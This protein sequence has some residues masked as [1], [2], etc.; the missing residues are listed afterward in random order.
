MAGSKSRVSPAAEEMTVNKSNRDKKTAMMGKKISELINIT[1]YTRR[2]QLIRSRKSWVKLPTC[3]VTE[4]PIA[5]P[6]LPGYTV[7]RDPIA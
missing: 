4:D 1:I 6:R 2:K 5:S 3:I 7:P